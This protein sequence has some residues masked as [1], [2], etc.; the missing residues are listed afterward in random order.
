MS[1]SKP[2]TTICVIDDDALVRQ[3]V[4]ELLSARGFSV[5]QAEDGDAGLQ[6]I[7][8]KRPSLIITDIMMPNRE[9]IETI[10]D[11]KRRFPSIPILVMSGSAIGGKANFLDFARKLGADALIVKPFDHDAFLQRVDELLVRGVD[12][13]RVDQDAD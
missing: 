12:K 4:A 3:L 13:A 2:T 6:I 10:R 1:D 9:G 5:L 11:A 8:D 7:A